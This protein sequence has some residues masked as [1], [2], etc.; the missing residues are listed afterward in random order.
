MNTDTIDLFISD[1]SPFYT[2]EILKDMTPREKKDIILD[3]L[4]DEHFDK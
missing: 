1:Y 3:I 4:E 2:L